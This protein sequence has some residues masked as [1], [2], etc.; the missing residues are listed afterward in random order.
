MLGIGDSVTFV[1]DEEVFQTEVETGNP[2]F[3]SW[4]RILHLTTK[5]SVVSAI[6]LT[7]DGDIL[8]GVR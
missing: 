7:N 4:L 1:V 6:G 8:D 3:V 2:A 5:G